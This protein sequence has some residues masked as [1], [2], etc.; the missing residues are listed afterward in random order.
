MSRFEGAR[1]RYDVND[2][3]PV[4]IAG[5]ILCKSVADLV[6]VHPVFK[7][8]GRSEAFVSL[9]TQD[10]RWG[11]LAWLRSLRKVSDKPVILLAPRALDVPVDI[12]NV[13]VIEVPALSNKNFEPGRPEYAHV[14]SKLWVFALTSL[15]RVAFIDIDC[16]F[17]GDVEALFQSDQFLAVANNQ[18]V[19]T[20]GRFNSG[21]MVFCPTQN[22]RRKVFR[23][24]CSL[25]SHMGG[26]E[27]ALNQILLDEV[28]FI[29]EK[30]NLFRHHHY[31]GNDFTRAD[32]RILHFVIKKPWEILYQETGDG[33]LVYLDDL[34]TGF[35]TNEER[36]ELIAYWRRNIFIIGEQQRI[37]GF[38]REQIAPLQ[39]QINA[40]EKQ[41]KASR[42]LHGLLAAVS[43]AAIVITFALLLN[44]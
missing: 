24:I 6:A 35:L 43:F 5:D 26:D 8:N 12:P 3:R 29:D 41:L 37:Q 32:V 2:V 39:K 44:R 23:K 15:D 42:L 21:V 40:L 30:Y 27:D 34:W 13:F 33:M 36:V 16:L 11:M 38:G 9:V 19:L 22:L 25:E 1:Q 4:E 10:Y 28:V 31:F 17:L 18:Y 14:L 7:H 20:A